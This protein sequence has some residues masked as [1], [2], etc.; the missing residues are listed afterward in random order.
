MNTLFSINAS[1]PLCCLACDSPQELRFLAVKPSR[2]GV[3]CWQGAGESA[4]H[5][6]LK[7]PWLLPLKAAGG[8][9]PAGPDTTVVARRRPTSRSVSG[10]V[11]ARRLY[12]GIYC[13]QELLCRHTLDRSVVIAAKSDRTSCCADSP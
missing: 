2:S 10:P 3:P 7:N 11:D 4:S 13:R 9:S 12:P 6:S 5:F 8:R 1:N